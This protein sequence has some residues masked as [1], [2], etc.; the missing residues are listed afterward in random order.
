MPCFVVNVVLSSSSSTTAARLPGETGGA[1]LAGET[2]ALRKC[3]TTARTSRVVILN[4]AANEAVSAS[5][6]DASTFRALRRINEEKRGQKRTHGRRRETKEKKTKKK[7]DATKNAV[8]RFSTNL[9]KSSS[10]FQK[11]S[12]D[13]HSFRLAVVRTLPRRII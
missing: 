3:S 8:S 11:P 10:D 5:G 12:P 2:C 6:N 9:Q 7:H 4:S 1:L 13:F